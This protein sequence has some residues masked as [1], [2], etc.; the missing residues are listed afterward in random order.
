MT[1]HQ[2]LID[3][4]IKRFELFKIQDPTN[5]DFDVAFDLSGKT[6]YA[7][8]FML[9]PISTTFKSILS[10][11]W[12]SPNE[13]IKIENYCYDDFF[14]FLKF[15]YS[16]EC[17]LSNDNILSMVDIAHVYD[18]QALK[19]VCKE[20]LTK[21]ELTHDNIYQFFELSN[22]YSMVALKESVDEYIEENYEILFKCKQFQSLQKNVIKNLVDEYQRVPMREELF[23]GLCKWAEKQ[24]GKLLKSNNDLDINETIKDILS[25]ILP[26]IEFEEMKYTFLM[27]F[28]ANK[29]FLFSGDRL[30]EILSP[31]DRLFV[32]V[33][34][35]NGKIM[36]GEVQCDDIEIIAASIQS[37][38]G[39][40]SFSHNS[41]ENPHRTSR[42]HWIPNESKPLKPSKLIKSKKVEWYLVYD[43]NGDFVISKRDDLYLF[44]DN[45]NENDYL[46]AEMYAENGFVGLDECK[47]EAMNAADF[48]CL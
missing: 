16:G 24:A 35:K 26:M 21:I 47:L 12:K 44:D 13:M 39:A 36:K 7:N 22:K 8:K 23:E 33:I 19:K 9:S 40:R 4:Q 5:G 10:K 17:K 32:K 41:V 11:R 34:D 46:L 28:V 1:S 15:I 29:A 18:I 20:Y 48:L 45:D 6:L 31:D 42:F 3:F 27:Q 25:E 37:V 2:I 14:E 43:N 30:A 38:K